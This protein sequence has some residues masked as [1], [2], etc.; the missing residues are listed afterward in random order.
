MCEVKQRHGYSKNVYH[1]LQNYKQLI[2]INQLRYQPGQSHNNEL[3]E[4]VS[5][6]LL[7]EI[8]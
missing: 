1:F 5:M 2:N 4:Y 8:R 3:V 7:P 6:V